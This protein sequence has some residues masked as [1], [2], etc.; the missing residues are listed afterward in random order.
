M[1]K[2]LQL[3]MSAKDSIN[4]RS[5]IKSNWKKAAGLLSAV[6]SSLLVPG[7]TYSASAAAQDT[8]PLIVLPSQKAHFERMAIMN[9][10]NY[11][12]P[13][14]K[15]AKDRRLWIG[16]GAAIV[17]AGGYSIYQAVEKKKAASVIHAFDIIFPYPHLHFFYTYSSDE[18]PDASAYQCARILCM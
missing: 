7:S 17:G 1:R 13:V 4:V 9:D 14:L 6:V 16:A 10:E 12:H 11:E 18:E 2:T 3:S 8:E 5:L 15:I